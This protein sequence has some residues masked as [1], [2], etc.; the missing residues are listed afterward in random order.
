MTQ[1]RA[2]GPP[3]WPKASHYK[4]KG[5]ELHEDWTHTS[6]VHSYHWAAIFFL[7]SD[8][9]CLTPGMHFEEVTSFMQAYLGL[10]INSIDSI[11]LKIKLETKND[12]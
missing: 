8:L 9:I 4:T 12:R 2:T 6:M 5:S 10:S 11:A 7:I 1:S 3:P